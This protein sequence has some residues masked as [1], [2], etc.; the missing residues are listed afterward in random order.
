VIIF[1]LRPPYSQGKS[2]QYPL[3][4]RNKASERVWMTS[5][6]YNFFIL[7]S[8]ELRL[9]AVPAHTLRCVRRLLV[10]VR[11]VPNSPILVTLMKE[12]LSS[13]ETTVLTRATQRN[14]PP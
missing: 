12:A 4:S 3:D 6:G 1:T 10:T 11:V 9:L 14:I 7:S 8:I 13:S 2:S 5:T